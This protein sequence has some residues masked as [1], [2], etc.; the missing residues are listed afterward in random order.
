MKDII[1][2]PHFGYTIKGSKFRIKDTT[3]T[4]EIDA[5]IGTEF[6]NNGIECHE[7]LNIGDSIAEFLIIEPKTNSDK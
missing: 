1:H 3:G 5:P 4:R 2:A 6:Y 7:F